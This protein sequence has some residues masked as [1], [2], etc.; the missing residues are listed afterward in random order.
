M[1]VNARELAQ[2]LEVSPS[3]ISIALNDR[4]GISRQTR[5]RILAAAAEHGL[6]RPARES[7]PARR[8]INL[9][10]FK[11]HGLVIGDTP[12]FSELI[13]SVTTAA[14]CLSYHIQLSYFYAAQNPAE[15]LKSINST[16]CAGVILL[17]TEMTEEDLPLLSEI[18]A[19]LVVLDNNVES[20]GFD[21]VVINNVQAAMLAAGHLLA[22]G[23]RRIGH[24]CSSVDI[25]N[26]RERR[27]GFLRAAAILADDPQS[28]IV[29]IPVESTS[30]G[31]YRDMTV[32]LARRPEL[33]Q[34]FFADNDIIAIACIRALKEAGCNIPR[35]LSI[36][37][38]DDV[39]YARV[40]S[41]RLTTMHVPRD[42]MGRYAI[43][44]LHEK[45]TDPNPATLK[46]AINAWL[47]DGDSV[48]GSAN[49]GDPADSVR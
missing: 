11:K 31:A 16:G 27:E 40:V 47:K 2:M 23:H 9:I 18:R 6:Q 37:G 38:F 36:I 30:D 19:P 39:P 5:E 48:T 8:Y 32:Y 15:Q 25:M 46:I 26:F 34:A 4:P 10:I 17:A 33:P 24:L 3:A 20:A 22:R 49:A 14:N 12:F 29:T 44:R 45:I 28:R 13:E 42:L 1:S 41:P 7:R 43:N 35:D 21:C